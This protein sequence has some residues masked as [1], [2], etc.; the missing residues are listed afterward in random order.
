[1]V[2]LLM[3]GDHDVEER[4]GKSVIVAFDESIVPSVVAWFEAHMPKCIRLVP[5][6]RRGRFV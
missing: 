6:K 2:A 3:A 1:M 4:Y 5:L